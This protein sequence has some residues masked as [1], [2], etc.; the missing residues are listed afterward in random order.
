MPGFFPGFAIRTVVALI[1]KKRKA[2]KAEKAAK[3]AE[4]EAKE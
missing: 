4:A 3:K 2:R 1:H